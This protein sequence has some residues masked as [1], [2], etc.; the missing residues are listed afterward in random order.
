M[1][2]KTGAAL[3]DWEGDVQSEGVG[4]SWRA[5]REGGSGESQGHSGG[6]E[7]GGVGRGTAEGQS[8]KEL[9]RSE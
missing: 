2:E 3:K 4:L 8:Q 6:W 1:P 5:W 9:F 7:L